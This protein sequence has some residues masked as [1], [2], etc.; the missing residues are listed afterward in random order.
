M[1][2]RLCGVTALLLAVLWFGNPAWAQHGAVDGEWPSYGGDLG[3]TKYSPLAQIDASNFDALRLV[4]AEGD[5]LPLVEL[6]E[7]AGLTLMP[8]VD[9]LRRLFAG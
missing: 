8:D 9:Q 6:F 1:N 7:R 2:R 3:S 5:S 4:W